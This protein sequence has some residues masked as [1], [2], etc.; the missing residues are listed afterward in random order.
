VRKNRIWT[1]AAGAV[2]VLATAAAAEA[3]RAIFLVRHG[4]KVD[5]SR[6]ADLNDAG[7]ARAALLAKL[8]RDSGITAVYSSDFQ[9]TRKTAQPL[10]DALGL[11]VMIIARE[12]EA[13]VRELRKARNRETV[14]LVAH[15]DTLPGILAGL[16]HRERVTIADAE[17]DNLFIVMPRA[18]AP[19]TVLRLRY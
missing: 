3:Q 12:A 6:D 2:I 16:G 15:S 8:L 13:V 7:R 10:A 18:G 14:L 19:P 17:Y 5:D 4:E 9:R 11:R 1:V